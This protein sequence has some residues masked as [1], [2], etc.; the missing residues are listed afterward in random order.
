MNSVRIPVNSAI[1]SH[2]PSTPTDTTDDVRCEVTL[3]W[4][5]ILAVTNTPTILANLILVVSERSVKSC[6]L[7]Q[8]V[9][10]VI[11]LAL[12]CRSSLM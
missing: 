7:A 3:F 9:S 12:G 8:L 10:L 6:K 2:V 11:V 1:T 4:A 5:V